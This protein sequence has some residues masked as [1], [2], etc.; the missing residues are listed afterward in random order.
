MR[1]FAPVFLIPA[2]LGAFKR[3]GR[4]IVTLLLM[5]LFPFGLLLSGVLCTLEW[6]CFCG[7]TF[8][9]SA[10]SSSTKEEKQQRPSAEFLPFPSHR[11]PWQCLEVW[12]WEQRKTNLARDST[13][14]TP[15]A[16]RDGCTEDSCLSCGK[17]SKRLYQ[18]QGESLGFSKANLPTSKETL[19][20]LKD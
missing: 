9:M 18:S 3:R 7:E 14:W 19:E 13:P 4:K 15:H 5:L 20:H 8:P 6:N 2:L 17:S 10:S 12:L 1:P 16:E 11:R